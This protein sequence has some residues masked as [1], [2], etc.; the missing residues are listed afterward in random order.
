[1]ETAKN[2][3]MEAAKILDDLVPKKNRGVE[4]YV[5]TSNESDT[6]S[7]CSSAQYSF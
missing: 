6:A 1:V 3:E 5:K 4:Q 7:N 2:L